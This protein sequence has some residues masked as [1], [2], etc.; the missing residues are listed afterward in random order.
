MQNQTTIIRIPLDKLLPHPENPNKMSKQTFEKLKRHIKQSHNYEPLIVRSH[1]ETENHFQIINGH[2]RADALRQLGETFADCVIW[3]IDDD[4]ARVLLAT[5]NRLSGKD[6]LS[7]KAELIKSL[8]EKFSSKELAKLLPDTKSAIERLKDITKSLPLS[9]DDT[10]AFLNTLVFF[11]NDEQIK[12]VEAALE[13]AM[14]QS[15][16]S[17]GAG[18]SEKLANAITAVAQQYLYSH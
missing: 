16:D 12:I 14:Q 10:K 1:P 6:E 2:H 9:E 8:S 7:L 13:K 5:L 15:R 3:N 17:N 11:L 18:K 4:Q